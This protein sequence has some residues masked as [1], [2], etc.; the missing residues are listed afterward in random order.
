[1]TELRICA[2]TRTLVHCGFGGDIFMYRLA[3]T[4]ARHVRA[5]GLTLYSRF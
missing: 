2:L 4:R 1:M 5:H 3:C